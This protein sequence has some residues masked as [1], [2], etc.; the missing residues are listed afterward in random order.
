MNA[1]ARKPYSENTPGILELKQR[2]SEMNKQA[3][4]CPGAECTETETRRPSRFARYSVVV[5][6]L[7]GLVVATVYGQQR[8]VQKVH[9]RRGFQQL[10]NN[11]GHKPTPFDDNSP[12]DNNEM[13]LSK[14]AI[15]KNGGVSKKSAF[16]N[17]MTAKKLAEM[18]E[19][20]L[21]ED[22]IVLLEKS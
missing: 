1:K 19:K 20:S 18:D 2:V 17:E 11:A 16:E 6:V 9:L 13:T 10:L 8:A 22:N 4:N 5:L 7:L 14:I 12:L 15:V 3:K 21:N